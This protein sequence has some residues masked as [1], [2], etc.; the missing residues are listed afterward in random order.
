MLANGRL[1]VQPPAA[2][3][4]LASRKGIRPDALAIGAALSRPWADV[5]LIGPASTAQLKAN[6]AAVEVHLD[7]E[8]L[9]TLSGVS[10]SPE[11]YWNERGALPWT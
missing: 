1:A 10:I 6:L 9:E 3:Q 5:V 11:R 8:E 7:E 4:T 2:A